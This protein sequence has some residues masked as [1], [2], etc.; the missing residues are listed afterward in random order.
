MRYILT[1]R[2]IQEKSLLAY[3][4]IRQ[5]YQQLLRINHTLSELLTSEAENIKGQPVI[6]CGPADEICTIITHYLKEN[7][8]PYKTVTEVETLTE[9]ELS[10]LPLVITWREEEEAALKGYPNVANIMKLV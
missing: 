10:L 1:P 5:S 3:N 6:L 7:S 4:Y 9:I 2:G 8:Q